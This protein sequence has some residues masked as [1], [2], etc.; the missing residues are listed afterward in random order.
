[1]AVENRYLD[2]Q[3]GDVWQR[4]AAEVVERTHTGDLP[5]PTHCDHLD[6]FTDGV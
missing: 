6:V 3:G 2:T 1:M 4:V 5:P